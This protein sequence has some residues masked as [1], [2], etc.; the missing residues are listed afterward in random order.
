M[1][2]PYLESDIDEIYERLHLFKNRIEGR[3]FLIT[4]SE[5]LLGVYLQAALSRFNGTSVF[6]IDREPQILGRKNVA[7]YKLDINHNKALFI[8]PKS[9]MDYII[10]LA[11]IASPRI[12]KKRS[13]DTLMTGSMGLM[14]SLNRGLRDNARVLTFSSSDVYGTAEV[15]PTPET[16]IGKTDNNNSRSPY[17]LSKK[18][19]EVISHTYWQEKALDVSIVRP[20]N[21]Y[22]PCKNDGRIIPN[23]FYKLVNNEP[24]EVF[25]G[26]IH[27]RTYQYI[28]DGIIGI[29]H[30]LVLGKRGEVYNIGNPDDEVSVLDLVAKMAFQTKEEI[31]YELV[32]YPKDYAG[33][34]NPLRKVPDITKASTHLDYSPQISLEEGLSRFYGWAKENY[35]KN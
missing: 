34:S 16:Y 22:G 9:E 23:F 8:E 11:S 14:N 32:D 26:G 30:A 21:I 6:C 13:I 7:F 19:T 33:E 5:G 28:T 27:T 2:A 31:K 35:L 18:Y 12:Y 17:D 10:C 20:F 25:D 4:G 24:L 1:K 15:I 29:M 3:N